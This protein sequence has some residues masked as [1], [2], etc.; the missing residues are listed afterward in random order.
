[1]GL[2]YQAYVRKPKTSN[3]QHVECNGVVFKSEVAVSLVET[4]SNLAL[5]SL[6]SLHLDRPV[7]SELGVTCRNLATRS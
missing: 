5:L 7:L 2:P 1:M 4:H 6:T 3:N